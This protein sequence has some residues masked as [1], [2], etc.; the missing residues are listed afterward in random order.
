MNVFENYS[1]YYDLLYRDKDYNKE[2]EYIENL[3]YR[4]TDKPKTILEL[5]CG[6]GKHAEILA[7]K[8][9][10]VYGVDFSR[11][12][13]EIAKK[14]NS[15][16]TK[17]INGNVQN[18]NLDK[19]FDLVL[20]LF[21]VANYQTTNEELQNYFLT[22]SKHLKPGG[23]FIFDSWYGPAVLTEKPQKREK[24][25]EN[26][27]LK[28]S[29]TAHPELYPNENIVEINYEILVEEK[30]S[31]KKEKINEKHIMRYL[32]LPEIKMMLEIAGL[33]LIHCEQWLTGGQLSINTWNSCFIAKA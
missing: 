31:K 27:T 33:N 3:I 30:I 10:E 25:I 12:M 7:K 9:F 20:S 1:A 16:G 15:A 19:K 4:F 26:N 29:R 23:I 28:L 8:G 5:G 21:H 17:F 18:I 24:T 22:A 6:T 11:T 32:F 14:R 13:L 2:I